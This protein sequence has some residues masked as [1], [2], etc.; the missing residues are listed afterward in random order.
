MF[1]KALLQTHGTKRKP[2]SILEAVTGDP[3]MFLVYSCAQSQPRKYNGPARLSPRMKDHSSSKTVGL[4]LTALLSAA[5]LLLMGVGTRWL[6]ASARSLLGIRIVNGTV[7]LPA[8][9][10]A[11][12]R[13]ELHAEGGVSPYHWTVERG[14]LPPGLILQDDGTIQGQAEVPGEYSFDA[15]VTDSSHQPR[16]LHQPFLLR[17]AWNGLAVVTSNSELPWARAG[18]EYLVRL[19]AAGGM[20]PYFWKSE[21]ALPEG[22]TLSAKGILAGASGQGGDFHFAVQVHDLRGNQAQ[23]SFSL[24]ISPARVDRFGGVVVPGAPAR[25]TGHW[26]TAKLGDRWVLLTPEGHPFWMIGIWD[27]TGDAHKDERG[28]SYDRRVTDKYGSGAVGWLQANRRLRSWGFNTIGPYSYRMMLPMDSEPEW[29]GTEQPVKLPFVWI[30]HNPAISGRKEGIFKNL[31]AGVDANLSVL[32]DQSSA[33]F[34]DVF[35]PAWVRNTHEIFTADRELAALAQSPYLIGVFGDDTD[36]LA[37]FG[38]GPEFVTQPPDKTHVHLGYLALITAPTQEKAKESGANYADA[39]VHTKAQLGDFLRQRYG[40]VEALNSAWGASYTTF[41]SDGGWPGGKGLLD[42]NGRASHR[43]LGSGDPALP[44]SAGANPNLVHDL[45]DFLYLIAHQFFSTEREALRTVAP[46][47]LFLGPTTIGGWWAPARAPIYRAAGES[48]DVI[49]ITTDGSQQQLD[50]IARAAGDIPLMV[51]E[52]VVANADSSQWRHTKRPEGSSWF[53]DSQAARAERYRRD[54]EWLFNS[55]AATGAHPFVGHLWW[56][57]TDSLTEER[58]WGVVSLMDN[59]YD[60]YE[61]GRTLG[62]DAWGFA[63][64]GEERNYGDFLGPV[65]TENFSVIERLTNEQH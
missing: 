10:H 18:S 27:V 16:T 39:Q 53:T 29:A 13:L 20:P 43:W 44:P 48:L 2:P 62:T 34:P 54:V 49:S 35:D 60:G 26:R 33:N 6:P 30:A 15:S 46:H 58:N 59:A 56:A 3:R 32:G 7:L 22:F 24:H 65:R 41:G 25:A 23:R 5:L 42:E 61:A 12:Y 57:W 47:A 11:G 55:R 37:G 64:G 52:G 31:Y 51:W 19:T 50:F 28:N 14:H 1:R 17:V 36:F 9:P 38:P 21:G 63:T 4:T 40:S 8:S 45:D